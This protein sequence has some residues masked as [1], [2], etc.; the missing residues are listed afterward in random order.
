[1]ILG[2][3]LAIAIAFIRYYLNTKDLQVSD[4]MEI[5]KGELRSN[6]ISMVI[7]R[8]LYALVTILLFA[9]LPFL[10]GHKSIAPEYFDRYSANALFIV[11]L[12]LFSCAISLIIL[13]YFKRFRSYFNKLY[14]DSLHSP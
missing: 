10:L 1:M 11:I 8:N 4:K 12:Y 6:L 14:H 2:L 9:G 7:D 5:I 3:G 13:I